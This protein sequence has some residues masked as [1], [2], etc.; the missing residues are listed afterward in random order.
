[1]LIG[2]G[3]WLSRE[4]FL[5][6]ALEFSEE[7]G[8]G[9]VMASV[10]FTAAAL[11]LDAGALPCSGGEGRVLQVAASIAAG[12]PVDLRDA[13]TGLDAAN[14]ALAAGAVLHASGHRAAEAGR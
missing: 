5:E 4:D 7:A 3:A 10:D 8:D 6:T 2:N 11:A 13:L 1:L 9:R 14:A 12:V